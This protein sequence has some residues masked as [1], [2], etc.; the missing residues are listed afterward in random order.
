MSRRTGDGGGVGDGVV[1]LSP[2]LVQPLNLTGSE[3]AE[4]IPYSFIHG[5]LEAFR[6]NGASIMTMWAF[7]GCLTPRSAQISNVYKHQKVI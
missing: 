1:F 4:P 7:A 5:A 6:G 3:A 2:G